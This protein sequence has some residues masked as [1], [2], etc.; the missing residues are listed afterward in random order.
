MTIEVILGE[1]GAQA[2]QKL[3]LKGEANLFLKKL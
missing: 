1:A 2:N 3:G